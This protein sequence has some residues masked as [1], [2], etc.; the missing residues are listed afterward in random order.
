MTD[1][2]YF[3]EIRGGAT[4][5]QAVRAEG[6]EYC[7]IFFSAVSLTKLQKESKPDLRAVAPR[8]WG[9]QRVVSSPFLPSTF[10]FDSA[11]LFGIKLYRLFASLHKHRP[12]VLRCA[13]PTKMGEEDP[14]YSFGQR[15]NRNFPV[16]DVYILFRRLCFHTP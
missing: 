15:R 10:S 6:K 8:F 13:F 1:S 9:V 7:K 4:A 5:Y 16:I 11:V 3:C 2:C 14:Y 12:L